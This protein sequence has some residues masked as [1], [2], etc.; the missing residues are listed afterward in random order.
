M[1]DLGLGCEAELPPVG[2]EVVSL[3]PLESAVDG[4]L[5]SVWPPM[6]GEVVS[7]G[8]VETWLSICD[9]L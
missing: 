4:M 9:I 7:S 3:L 8:L 5:L 1:H 2:G 6:G